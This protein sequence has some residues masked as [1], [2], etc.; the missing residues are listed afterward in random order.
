MKFYWFGDSWVFG[1]ELEL[2]VAADQR[3]LHTFATLVSEHYQANCVNLSTCGSSLNS[4]PLEFNKIVNDIDPAID[5]VF[6]F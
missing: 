5:R 4:I 1:D 6:F 3:R 2:Q